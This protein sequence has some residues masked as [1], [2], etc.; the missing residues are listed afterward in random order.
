MNATNLSHLL[1]C[2][3]TVH[4]WAETTVDGWKD[5]IRLVAAAS[6]TG[7]AAWATMVP[8][9]IEDVAAAAVVRER[10]VAEL[11]GVTYADRVV[12]H[13]EDG[14]TVIVDPL[15]DGRKRIANAIAR[16]GNG[17]IS[18]QRLSSVLSAPAPGEPDL[19]VVLGT[20]ERLPASLVWE[21]AYA[22]LVFLDAP[23][24]GLDF[25]HLEMAIDDFSR[26]SRR[27]GGLDS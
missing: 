8:N 2:A 26:R 27:F 14:V 15:A 21:L 11:D 3:G 6:N 23:W 7:G 22:E 18:E 19:I 9:G 5:R 20:A 13:S 25:E 10:L 1:L 4:E 24:N 12:L 16:L 17:I